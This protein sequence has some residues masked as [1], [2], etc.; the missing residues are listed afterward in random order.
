MKN[1]QKAIGTLVLGLCLSVVAVLGT[2]VSAQTTTGYNA[3]YNSSGTSP[4][5][6][7]IDATQFSGTDICAQIAAAWTYAISTK[8]FAGA[9]IDAR[10]ITGAQSCLASP[11]PSGVTVS[12]VLLL[13]NA[14]ITTS[15][16]WRIPS[17]VRVEGIGVAGLGAQPTANTKIIAGSGLGL[18]E[19]GSRRATLL[20]FWS[21]GV[22]PASFQDPV[23]RRN[24][25]CL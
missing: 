16:T 13:G 14:Q 18:E 11:F 1:N 10:G 21:R 17:R 6:A 4:S 19:V 3:V 22:L 5:P 8:G 23:A 15:V 12:G 9:T 20:P 7:F 24:S 25:V 2:S